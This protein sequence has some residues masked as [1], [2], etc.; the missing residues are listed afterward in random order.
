MQR[1][2]QFDSTWMPG[3]VS[4][5][6]LVRINIILNKIAL[7]LVNYGVQVNPHCCYYALIPSPLF[8]ILML[9]IATSD[10][11]EPGFTWQAGGRGIST[12]EAHTQAGE[13]TCY[14]GVSAARVI[15]AYGRIPL[16]VGCGNSVDVAIKYQLR[17]NGRGR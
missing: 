14:R 4:E 9:Q 12:S 15:V 8:D 17:L 3:D 5:N 7:L 13:L 6:P 16:E 11:H 1:R 10:S 2:T